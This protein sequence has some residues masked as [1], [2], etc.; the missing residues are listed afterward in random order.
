[1]RLVDLSQ[2]LGP[3]IPR[4]NN[5]VP[6]PRLDTY[7][8]HAEAAASGRYENCSCE[9]HRV[10]FIT[11]MSTYLDSPYHFD[12]DGPRIHELPLDACVLPGVCVDC[13]PLEPRQPIPA[14]V[15]DGIDLDGKAVLFCTGW[16]AYWDDAPRYAAYPFLT[17][18]IAAR[19]RD[20]GARLCGVDYLA[21]DDQ[22]DLT[23]PVHTTL[24]FNRILI[25]ENLTN[26]AALIGRDFV[27]H[28]APVRMEGAAAF[29]VRA[30]AVLGD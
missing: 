18:A 8:S 27:L 6:L 23:R 1:M 3:N 13:R 16:S 7:L 9:V 5:Q 15:L 26:L 19:L 22:T 11:S 12:P 10:E 29:P 17:G 28:A 14:S 21:A 25:V 24:L 20:G 2:S 30:Y 4:F